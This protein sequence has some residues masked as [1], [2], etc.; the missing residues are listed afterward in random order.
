MLLFFRSELKVEDPNTKFTIKERRAVI[1]PL[2]LKGKR[3]KE[4]YMSLTLG[5]KSPSYSTVKNWVARCKNI[6]TL[7]VKTVHIRLLVVNVPQNVVAI[8]SMIVADWNFSQK[9]SRD[10]GD[11][12]RNM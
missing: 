9:D 10:S 8:H 7:K 4:I 2:F 5:E 1:Q 12:F 6:S 3:A 11:R